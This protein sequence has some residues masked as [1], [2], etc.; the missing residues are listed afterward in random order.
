MSA[1]RWLAEKIDK[2]NIVARENAD[3]DIAERRYV[4]SVSKGPRARRRVRISAHRGR[5]FRLIV[6]GI[7]A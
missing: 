2:K 3:Y 5:R 6:D 4:S 7:S 1:L